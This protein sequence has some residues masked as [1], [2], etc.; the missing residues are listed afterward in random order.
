MALTLQNK[1]RIDILLPTVLA[2]IAGVFAFRKK[3]GDWRILVAAVLGGFIVSYIIVSQV[4]RYIYANGPAPVPT[5]ADGKNYDG[6]PLAQR[7]HED[8]YSLGFRNDAP[9]QDLLALSD[10][11][12]IAVYNA[13][14]A[15]FFSQDNETLPTAIAGE[16]SGWFTTFKDLQ[17]ALKVRFEKLGL[18]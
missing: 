8:I 6:L 13:W 18:T 12:F 4:T 9:Y 2:C 11:Q 15:N 14:N 5:G 10:G 17:A 16:N 3:N 1:R 7:L